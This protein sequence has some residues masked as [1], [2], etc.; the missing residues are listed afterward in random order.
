MLFFRILSIVE[1]KHSPEQE[2]NPH[3][4]PHAPHGLLKSSEAQVVD[5][6]IKGQIRNSK[7]SI[8]KEITSLN[9]QW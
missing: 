6:L 8:Y 7:Y 4:I 3:T 9:V 5:Y 1:T 2:K